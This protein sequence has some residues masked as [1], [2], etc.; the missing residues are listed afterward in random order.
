M[1]SKFVANLNNGNL[2]S[3]L[4]KPFTVDVHTNYELKLGVGAQAF[5]ED[6]V[7]GELLHYL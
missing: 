1:T 5:N 2:F 6:N 4:R 3:P 7:N